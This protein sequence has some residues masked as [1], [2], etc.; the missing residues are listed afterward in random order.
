MVAVQSVN[1][2]NATPLIVASVTP[3]R[4]GPTPQ[5]FN[6]PNKANGKGRPGC[7]VPPLVG[8]VAVLVLDVR[9][10]RIGLVLQ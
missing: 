4:A 9:A 8:A 3:C 5:G 7:L 2:I 6:A 10:E 1:P